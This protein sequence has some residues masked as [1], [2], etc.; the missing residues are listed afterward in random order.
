MAETVV[1]LRNHRDTVLQIYPLRHPLSNRSLANV[2]FTYQDRVIM[3]RRSERVIEFDVS[4]VVGSNHGWPSY[5]AR[6][7]IARTVA[8]YVYFLPT[9]SGTKSSAKDRAGDVRIR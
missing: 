6:P 2:G 4:E 1:N 7:E 9:A 8:E 3:G 5:Y